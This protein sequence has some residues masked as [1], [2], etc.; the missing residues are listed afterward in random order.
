VLSENR[1]KADDDLR[2]SNCPHGI[3]VSRLHACLSEV[4]TEFCSG[5]MS[6]FSRSMSCTTGSLCP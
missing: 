3:D 4:A 2:A 6:G 5:F 1:G